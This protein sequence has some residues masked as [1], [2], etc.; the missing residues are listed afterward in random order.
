MVVAGGQ[1]LTEA[2]AT[3]S[4]VLLAEL[5]TA[6]KTG[7]EAAAAAATTAAAAATIAA[8]ASA[9]AA[10]DQ[11]VVDELA[12]KAGQ[13]GIGFDAKARQDGQQPGKESNLSESERAELLWEKSSSVKAEFG[14]SKGAF[15]M[16]VKREGIEQF[17][18]ETA[19]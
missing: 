7:D 16:C 13:P 19:V 15:L 2:K 14:Q 4:E 6:K 11:S 8:A 17:E 9:K 12:G 18:K 5:A 10:E 1:S 3:L